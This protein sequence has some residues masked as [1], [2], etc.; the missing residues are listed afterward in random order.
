MFR[1]PAFG[2]LTA[3]LVVSIGMLLTTRRESDSL[4]DMLLEIAVFGFVWYIYPLIFAIVFGVPLYLLLNRLNLIHW[5]LSVAGG[6][7]I[8]AIGAMSINGQDPSFI[9]RL[10]ALGG[11][12]GLVFWFLAGPRDVSGAPHDA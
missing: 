2:F 6:L 4:P 5:S 12:A 9:A 3:P 7:L 10:V 8:G 1:R 11:L